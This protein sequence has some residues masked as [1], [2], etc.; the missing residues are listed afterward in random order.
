M[1]IHGSVVQVTGTEQLVVTIRTQDGDI[2]FIVPLALHEHFGAAPCGT[3]IAIEGDFRILDSKIYYNKSLSLTVGGREI[4]PGFVKLK[5]LEKER[6]CNVVGMV[7]GWHEPKQSQGSDFVCTIDIV[8]ET[9]SD[10]VRV[11]IFT[12]EK[13][14]EDG[15]ALGDIVEIN[16]VKMLESGVCLAGKKVR[17][18]T[19]HS[20]SGCNEV[21]ASSER[22]DVLMTHYPSMKNKFARLRTIEEVET[23]MF[24]DIVVQLVNVQ[25]ESESLVILTVVD[26]TSHAGI[27]KNKD[28]MGFRNNMVMFVKAW[29]TYAKSAK[30]LRP[31]E[32]LLLRNLK[33]NNVADVMTASLSGSRNGGVTRLGS[34]H[35]L[36][37]ALHAR[38]SEFLAKIEHERSSIETLPRFE[39]FDL[40]VIASLAGEGVYRVRGY[41]KYTIPLRPKRIYRCNTCNL[42]RITPL[43][44]C[45]E[46][47]DRFDESICRLLL[48]DASGS[49]V[50]MCKNKI[51]DALFLEANRR[52][53]RHNYFDSIVVRCTTAVGMV[54]SMVDASFIP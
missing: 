7:V 36:C 17:V 54:N 46:A 22:V 9:V 44:G 38:K 21:G 16:C 5:D 12:R 19:L 33:I 40:R 52:F 11:K 30:D 49:A 42:A 2:D 26:Y 53:T 45:S 27:C 32:M 39:L 20:Q 43:T 13:C 10:K 35:S 4:M 1:L 47:C 31:N 15:F 41:I 34:D 51:L 8:D 6:Y 29:E 48:C 18:R 23:N 25:I 14:F 37:K 24:C 50:V 3:A 28:I